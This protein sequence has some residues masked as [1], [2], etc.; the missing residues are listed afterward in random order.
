MAKSLQGS[1]REYFEMLDPLR[2][3]LRS[4]LENWD[5]PVVV[6]FG[7]ESSGKSTLLERL[8]TLRLFPCDEKICTR[9]PIRLELRASSEAKQ[10][11]L[12]VVKARAN[13]GGAETCVGGP[14]AV[15]VDTVREQMHRT[16]KAENRG[17][18]GVCAT[19]YLRLR[20]EGTDVPNIDLLDLPG[21]VLMRR[22]GEPE[23]M[24]QQTIDLVQSVVSETRGRALYL[25]V[26]GAGEAVSS[27]PIFEVLRRNY[28][29]RVDH[30]RRADEV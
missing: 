2:D 10:P 18:T 7:A 29:H 21:I 8:T 24:T 1:L 16:L 17:V 15:T 26:R 6:V 23:D 30:R 3:V 14:G 28:G 12:F 22:D 13:G 25:A 11:Q 19:H 5:T 20:V 27:C 4:A 9:L